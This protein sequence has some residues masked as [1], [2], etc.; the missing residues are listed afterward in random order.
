MPGTYRPPSQSDQY[1]FENADTTLDIYCYY[2][3]ILLTGDFNAEI[4]DY[5]LET[6]L[7]QHGLKSFVKEKTCFESISNPSCIDL[8]L[9]N[10]KLSFQATKQ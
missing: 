2:D 5:Y 1:F 4:Y 8:F 3:E 9:T 10:S 6:L 7:Y